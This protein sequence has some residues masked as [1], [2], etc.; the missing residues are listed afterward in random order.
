MIE[1]HLEKL[2]SFYIAA[3]EKSLLQAAEII[4]VTQPAITKSIRAIEAQLDTTLLVRHNRGVELTSSG[5]LLYQFCDGLF[6]KARSVER[7][8]KHAGELTGIIRIG[9]YETLGELF[10]PKV[11]KHIHKDYPQLTIELTTQDP[12]HIWTK[13]AYGGVDLIVDAEPRTSD[14]LYSRVL[15]TDHFGI[16]CKTGSKFLKQDS[17]ESIPISYVQRA[18]DRKGMTLDE[19]LR[20]LDL[21]FECLYSVESFT[22]TRSF[23]L[24]D[25]C[26][27]VLPLSMAQRYLANGRMQYFLSRQKSNPH[28]GEHRICAT[29]LDHAKNDPKVTALIKILKLQAAASFT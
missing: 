4:G 24:E 19:H 5:L 17:S 9:T 23:I 20:A 28:F 14:A 22:L 10:W 18:T 3:Q 27:G 26:V 29:I 2:R 12:A 11:L 7:E 25:V 6:L 13:L 16:F 8:I 21:P 15:Y 1:Q